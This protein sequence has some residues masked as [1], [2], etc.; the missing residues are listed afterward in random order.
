MRPTGEIKIPKSTSRRAPRRRAAARFTRR[1]A[2]IPAEVLLR[3]LRRIGARLRGGARE[4]LREYLGGLHRL[5]F[6]TVESATYLSCAFLNALLEEAPAMRGELTQQLE[7][8][9]RGRSP[10]PPEDPG[11]RGRSLRSRSGRRRGIDPDADRTRTGRG[12]V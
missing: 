1:L 10:T 5:G 4:V 12:A 3:D 2:E 8:F 6:D 11:G 7:R 9:L